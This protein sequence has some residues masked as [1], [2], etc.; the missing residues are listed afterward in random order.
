MDAVGNGHAVWVEVD[1]L[2]GAQVHAARFAREQSQLQD[3]GAISGTTPVSSVATFGGPTVG[4]NP[5]VVV[6]AAGR[7]L[8]VWVGPGGG[9]WSAR[10]E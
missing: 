4:Y 8:A 3:L 10:F 5:R 6:D 7:A 9:I 1:S 2:G